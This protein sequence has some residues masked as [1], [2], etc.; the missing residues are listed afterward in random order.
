MTRVTAAC[1]AVLILTGGS[2]AAAAPIVIS[3]VPS[4]TWTHGCGP[5]AAGSIFGYWDLHGYP[6]LFDAAGPDVFL[7]ANVEDQI[8]SPAHNLKYD[9]TPDNP[10][11]PDPPDT[12]IAD[13]FHT[14][15]GGL[16]TGCSY[17][18]Y[19]VEAL[20]GYAAYRGYS[21]LATDQYFYDGFSWDRFTSEIDAG[22]PL[23]F[24]VDTTGSG[25][26][27]HFVPAIGYDDRGPAGL[28]Y[29]LYSTWSEE[30]ILTW[31]PF[32][33]IARGN[34]WGI[35]YVTYAIPLDAPVPEPATFALVA[36][37]LG[38]VLAVRRTRF[39]R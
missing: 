38:I 15:E 24:L 25:S 27:N 31:E 32:A 35:A 19:A 34:G 4:Y 30:E 26:T 10:D 22:R 17:Q 23:L 29:G 7:T 33:G 37:G 20:T 3:D 16:D 39:S 12:S 13:F 9:P 5:T 1:A 14:S 21:F 6:N 8:S 11:L 28:W 36:L 2:N 18:A